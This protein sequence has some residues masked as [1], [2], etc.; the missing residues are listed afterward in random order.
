MLQ[1]ALLSTQQGS[2]LN[3]FCP[4]FTG[5]YHGGLFFFFLVFI[6]DQWDKK[7]A[8]N[9]PGWGRL[10]ASDWVWTQTGPSPAWDQRAARRT[11]EAVQRRARGDLPFQS[12][13][14]FSRSCLTCFGFVLL[15]AA[16]AGSSEGFIRELG[17][18]LACVWARICIFTSRF[19][20]RFNP[21]QVQ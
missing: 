13:N 15:S 5:C 9:S 14:L 2:L 21:H 6:G 3:Y 4:V 19:G 1:P 16:I 8:R 10:G 12:E 11:S 17:L 7:E 20:S 18:K